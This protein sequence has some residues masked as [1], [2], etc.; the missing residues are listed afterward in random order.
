MYK[1]IVARDKN[2]GIGYKNQIPWYYKKDLEF[3]KYKTDNSVVIMGYKT[4]E[5]LDFKPLS[6]R[7]NIIISS[8]YKCS[9]YNVFVFRSIDKCHQF[10]KCEY[11]HLNKWVIGG[12]SIYNAYMKNT[13]VSDI[14]V[15]QFDFET[16]A[17]KYFNYFIN[18][19]V[20]QNDVIDFVKNE[21]IDIDDFKVYHYKRL[22][23]M[24]V[25]YEE[26]KLL[27]TMNDIIN[28]GFYK[29]NRTGVNT[30]S[31]YGK[32]FEY[33]MD[34]EYDV[35]TR[36]YQYRLPLLTT[37]KMFIRGVFEELN[38]IL[39]GLTNS[40]ILE[41][42]K[43]NIWTGNS[44]REYLDS[45]NLNNYEE[46][47]CGPIYGFQ[48]IH[49]GAKYINGK[50][51]YK[52]EGINQVKNVINSLKNNPYSRRHIISGWNV[53]DLDQ[54]CL[55]PC[56]VLY[57]FLVHETNN[58]KY[59]T[60]MMTQRSCDTFLGLPFNIC[61]LGLFLIMMAKQV[62]MIPYKII[63]SIADMHI[64][65]NHIDAVKEQLSRTPYPF[66]YISLNV[67]KENIE[68]YE[69][70]DFTLHSYHYHPSIKADMVA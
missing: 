35:D 67:K 20:D 31:L 55:P 39:K 52:N 19:K 6:N 21:V 68:D 11:K 32:M 46:G 22:N 62:D 58:R 69:F 47:E 12:E 2:N 40:K 59:L 18:N 25:N 70:N 4:F 10:L 7:I 9:M 24:S 27:N 48:W 45:I 53:S 13:M 30:Y 15:T 36:N 26:L 42:K 16:P 60:L 41:K 66:P 56:H 3:F 65:E 38:W 63:H 57:Q 64:Y 23:Y 54:M 8:K 50:T 29:E 49:W 17:D 1:I 34:K 51:E 14:Y 61:S 43:V 5:S 44:S 37:K 33:I 28:T